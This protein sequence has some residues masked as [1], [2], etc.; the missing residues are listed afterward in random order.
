MTDST[1]QPLVE[2]LIEGVD[3]ELVDV[4]LEPPSVP[5]TLAWCW[6]HLDRAVPDPSRVQLVV[7]GYMAGSVARWSPEKDTAGIHTVEHGAGLSAGKTIRLPD[8]RAVVLLHAHHFRNDLDRDQTEVNELIARRV[9]VH[10]TQHVV[11]HQNRQVYQPDATASFRDLN[12]V[13]GAAA[14]IEEYRAEI[15]VG[16]EFRRG[17]PV[18][19]PAAVIADLQANLDTAVATYQGHRSVDRLV[20]EVTSSVLIGWR[21]LAYAAARDAV[22][23]GRDL[24]SEVGTDPVWLRGFDEAWP[25]FT[26]VLERIG[27]ADAVMSR[28]ALDDAAAEFAQILGLSMTGLGFRWQGDMFTIEPWF[29]ET[30]TYGAARADAVTA[31]QRLRMKWARRPALGG[32][33]A[34]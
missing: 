3:L 16:E 17:E 10:E 11:M 24:R 14:I 23:P 1:P 4:T 8:G 33:I 5:T 19:E 9:L 27:P 20:F 26:A 13:G 6:A 15:S 7:T 12:L 21:G 28:Q 31:M 29:V 34:S 18:W 25:A 2:L 22:V 32:R 30:S